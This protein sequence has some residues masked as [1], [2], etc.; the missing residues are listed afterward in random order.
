MDM[1]S[2]PSKRRITARIDLASVKDVQDVELGETIEVVVTGK[3]CCLRG[4]SQEM[5]TNSKGK[6]VKET[7]PGTLELEIEGIKVAEV[8]TFDAMEEDD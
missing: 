8:G 3:V 2:G 1:V 4:P 7:Y 5:W 6:D